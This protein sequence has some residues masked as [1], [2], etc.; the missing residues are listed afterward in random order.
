M[1]K[2]LFTLFILLFSVSIALASYSVFIVDT[3]KKYHSNEKCW[4]LK[5]SKEIHK[6]SLEEAKEKGYTPCGVCY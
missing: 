4:T 6:L 3:G 5:K 1:K 2:L